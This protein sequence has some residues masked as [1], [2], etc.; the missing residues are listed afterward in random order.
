MIRHVYRITYVA[1]SNGIYS[2]IFILYSRLYA[3]QHH[4]IGRFKYK[5]H[6]HFLTMRRLKNKQP[7]TYFF[8]KINKILSLLWIIVIRVKPWRCHTPN[9]SY[10]YLYSLIKRCYCA[11]LMTWHL[12]CFIF[13]SHCVLLT[14][15]SWFS[16]EEKKNRAEKREITHLFWFITVSIAFCVIFFSFVYFFM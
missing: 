7:S 16:A 14:N 1:R 5:R 9:D 3:R 8:F 4:F 6:W 13:I 11:R 12:C 2:W 15:I 10:T